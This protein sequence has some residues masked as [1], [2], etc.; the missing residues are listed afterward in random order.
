MGKGFVPITLIENL[1]LF[2]FFYFFMLP[3][4]LFFIRFCLFSVKILVFL[5]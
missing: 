2:F 3:V 4:H 5:L 1:N